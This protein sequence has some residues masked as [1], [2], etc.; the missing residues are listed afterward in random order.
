MNVEVRTLP[1][2]DAP[3]ADGQRAVSRIAIADGDIHPARRSIQ[4]FFP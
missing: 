3:L 4:D 2:P 1:T